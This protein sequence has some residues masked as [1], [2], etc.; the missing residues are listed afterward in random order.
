MHFSKEYK[1]A[2][3]EICNYISA[4]FQ[5]QPLIIVLPHFGDF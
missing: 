5:K 4:E 3:I 1:W 2:M